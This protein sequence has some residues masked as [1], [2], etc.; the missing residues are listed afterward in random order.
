MRVVFNGTD[1]TGGAPAVRVGRVVA[2]AG[3]QLAATSG[4]HAD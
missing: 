4:F 1:L 2:R 3:A